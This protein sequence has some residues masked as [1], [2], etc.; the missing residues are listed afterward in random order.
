MARQFLFIATGLLFLL[1]S[2]A[3]YHP[4]Y[5]VFY[6]SIR[7]ATFKEPGELKEASI[8]VV[9]NI[10][11][12]GNVNVL[13]KNLTDDILTVDQT[14]SFFVDEEKTSKSFYDPTIR[15]SSTTSANSSS[16]GRSFNLG[17]VAQ[18][19]GIGGAIGT[20]LNA[21]SV[22]GSTTHG[23]AT[24]VTVQ[25]K[26][27]P[28]I[29][30]AP[31]G[32]MLLSKT[33]RYNTLNNYQSQTTAPESSPQTCS[34]TVAY[35]FDDGANWDK[36]TTDF[37][38]NASLVIPVDNGKTNDAIRKLIELKP[39]ITKEP[40]FIM[41]LKTQGSAFGPKIDNSNSFINFQ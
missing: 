25:T 17:A 20:I 31:R 32:Q 24:T 34:V 13:V 14:R 29:T 39:N 15:T 4:C 36:I 28:R 6:K 11:K 10:D 40:W 9:T 19:L 38:T 5:G 41:H 8:A 12:D 2:C 26:D 18:I 3:S 7:P 27:M 23:N 16:I 30:I 22:T 35:S 21:S 37:F 33:F 1:S